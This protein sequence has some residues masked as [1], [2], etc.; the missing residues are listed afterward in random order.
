MPFTKLCI[1]AY[2]TSLL[3]FMAN[4]LNMIVF[5]WIFWL[6]P[7]V[8]AA[9]RSKLEME[10]NENKY[11]SWNCIDVPHINEHYRKYSDYFDISFTPVEAWA[12]TLNNLNRLKGFGTR[13]CGF[14]FLMSRSVSCAIVC[15]YISIISRVLTADMQ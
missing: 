2:A 5:I 3:H 4:I 9:I 6:D 11:R 12:F 15:G 14:F 1:T 13:Y 8:T 7:A 10:R